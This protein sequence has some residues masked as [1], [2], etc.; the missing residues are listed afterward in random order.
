MAKEIEEC[1]NLYNIKEVDFFTA[2]FTIDKQRVTR[3]CE[4][5]KKRGLNID[6][7]C[8][9]RIDTV[10]SEL[11]QKMASAGCKRIYYGIESGDPRIL[12][13]INKD[14]AL[15]QVEKTIKL[16][17]KYGIKTLGFFMVGNQG[18]T[19]RSIENTMNF[20]KKLKL[21]FIQVGRT[22]AKPNSDLDGEMKNK[23]G[24]DYWRDFILGREKE[25]RLPNLWND[26]TEKELQYYTKK[27]YTNLYF[28]PKYILKTILKMKSVHEFLRYVKT[29]GEMIFWKNNED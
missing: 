25:K 18:E 19:K 21:D 10:N 14:I 1:Y 13:I 4:E 26:L 7:S 6:W 15:K 22:I 5:I 28:N 24:R 23:T 17:Q 12:R 29:G 8:R 20:A 9:S 16:T 11:L 2:T 27:M 3:F